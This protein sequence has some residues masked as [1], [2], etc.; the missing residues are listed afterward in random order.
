MDFRA[1]ENLGAFD[2]GLR[3]FLALLV[4]LGSLWALAVYPDWWVFSLFG[5][6]VVAYLLMTAG[7]RVDPAYAM[8]NF[9]TSRHH[10][11][12]LRRRA[13]TRTTRP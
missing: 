7:I 1:E 10:R 8:M 12:H 5:V 9:D 2:A 11:P 3:V 6:V 13:R 4:A